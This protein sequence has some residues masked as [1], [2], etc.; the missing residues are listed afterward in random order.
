[1]TDDF[2][3]EWKTGTCVY[4]LHVPEAIWYALNLLKIIG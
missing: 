3:G 2:P 1:M 4:S